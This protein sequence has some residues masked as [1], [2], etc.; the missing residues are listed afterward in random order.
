MPSMQRVP[1]P[2]GDSQL[3]LRKPEM[4]KH[5]CLP[6]DSLDTEILSRHCD[7]FLSI[8]GVLYR[9][10]SSH[11]LQNSA[12]KIKSHIQIMVFFSFQ[13]S[14]LYVFSKCYNIYCLL[15]SLMSLQCFSLFLVVLLKQQ[16]LCSKC[17]STMFLTGF[18]CIES[19]WASV[20][21]CFCV[22]LGFSDNNLWSFMVTAPPLAFLCSKSPKWIS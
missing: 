22:L 17:H 18:Y 9:L 19:F 3:T 14:F 10:L 15:P 12:L 1:S 6:L 21:L 5:S 7:C 13:A 16:K 11:C 8:S 20:D 2:D 4:G